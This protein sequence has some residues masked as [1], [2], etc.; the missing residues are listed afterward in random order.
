V[1]GAYLSTQRLL[2]VALL[3]VGLAMVV[4]TLARGGGPAAL[5]VIAGV[6]FAALGVL[7]LKL[8]GATD[9]RRNR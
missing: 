9:P 3:V 5:G 6:M 4:S 2:G 1:S 8:A 7:R